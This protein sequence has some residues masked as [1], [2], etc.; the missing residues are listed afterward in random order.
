MTAPAGYPSNYD[1]F[2][3]QQAYGHSGVPIYRVTHEQAKAIHRELKLPFEV[4]EFREGD[5][6][7][8]LNDGHGKHHIVFA[9]AAP[10]S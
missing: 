5:Q 9:L 2:K 4:Q 1:Q 10:K 7:F 6:C 3:D 8:Y